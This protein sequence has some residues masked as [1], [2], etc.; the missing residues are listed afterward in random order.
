MSEFGVC[1]INA[2]KY[3]PHSNKKLAEGLED[4]LKRDFITTSINEKW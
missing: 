4:V 2:K 1:V 3:K